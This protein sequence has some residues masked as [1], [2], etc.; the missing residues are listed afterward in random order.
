[1][2]RR[3]AI[4]LVLLPLLAGCPPAHGTAEPMT[5]HGLAIRRIEADNRVVLA[6]G[7]TIVG[8]D[9]LAQALA[10]GDGAIVDVAVLE[11][12]P[13]VFVVTFADGEVRRYQSRAAAR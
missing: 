4:L 12:M 7:L 3:H 11:R 9:K 10:G 2:S 6:D 8:D 1:M 13:P 5:V